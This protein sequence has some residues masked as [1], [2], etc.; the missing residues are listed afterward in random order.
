MARAWLLF[1]IMTL[2]GGQFIYPDQYEMIT[3]DLGRSSA[4]L[5]DYNAAAL[6]TAGSSQPVQ[7]DQQ[8]NQRPTSQFGAARPAEGQLYPSTIRVPLYSSANPTASPQPMLDTWGNHVNHYSVVFTRHYNDY[9]ISRAFFRSF[10]LKF[11]LF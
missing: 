11:Y 4:S 9:S 3:A 10:Y 6:Q 1:G 7:I 2:G 5:H 8:L